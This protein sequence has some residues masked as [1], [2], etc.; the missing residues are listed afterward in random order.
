MRASPR[1]GS[2]TT[3]GRTARR[4]SSKSARSRARCVDLAGL[5]VQMVVLRRA[6]AELGRRV[7]SNTTEVPTGRSWWASQR[8][9][10]AAS[11]A[12]TRSRARLSTSEPVLPSPAAAQPVDRAEHRRG[13]REERVRVGAA[14]HR[15]PGG[16]GELG[17]AGAAVAPPSVHGGVVGTPQRRER[18]LDTRTTA[19]PGRGPGRARAP[20]GVVVGHRVE[21]GQADDRVED[22]VGEREGIRHSPAPVRSRGGGPARRRSASGERSTPTTAPCSGEPGAVAAGSAAGVEQRGSVR[23]SQGASRSAASARVLRYHQW[24][25]ST[26]AMRAYSS[27]ST[28]GEG[29]GGRGCRE[30][31]SARGDAHGVDDEVG[32]RPRLHTDTVAGRTVA[33]ALGRGLLRGSRPRAPRPRSPGRSGAHR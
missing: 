14:L 25:S 12:N 19:P 4:S 30:A 23:C 28:R 16:G 3:A 26:S 24:S 5:W 31:R 18:R 29:T 27:S 8:R 33:A 17:E 1:S 11:G 21:D 32:R 7:A 2:T 13:W 20:R 6:G 15:E 9:S 22:L 10:R